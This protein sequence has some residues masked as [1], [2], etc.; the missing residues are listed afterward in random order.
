[1]LLLLR[2]IVAVLSIVLLG[3]FC[4]CLG[5]WWAKSFESLLARLGLL[6]GGYAVLLLLVWTNLGAF[7]ATLTDATP[8]DT[9]PAI[10]IEL[11]RPG[12]AALV[13]ALFILPALVGILVAGSSEK[14]AHE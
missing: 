14:Q 13:F 2:Q 7:L 5:K 4:Y 8:L 10:H 1:L 9:E 6:V 3:Y 12:Q 11:S